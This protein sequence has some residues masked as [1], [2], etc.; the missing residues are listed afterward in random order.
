MI[1]SDVLLRHPAS[2]AELPRDIVVVDW[3]Y[4]PT[5]SF[6]SLQRLQDLGFR[7][8]FVSP[9]LWTWNTFY[10]N[11]AWAFQNISAF[12][13]AGKR[14]G[15]MG[16]VAASWGDNGAENLRENNWPG[17]AYS[18]AAG[19]EV[20]TPSPDPFFRRYVAVQYGVDSPALAEAERLLGWQ[21]FEQ[22][23]WAGRLYHR[24]PLVRSRPIAWTQRMQE[25][26]ADMRRVGSDLTATGPG[27]RFNEDHLAAV[28]HC[29]ARY[30]YIADREL[31]LDSLGRA[32]QRHAFAE[33][34][35]SEQ[36]R[37]NDELSALQSTAGAL[38]RQFGELWLKRNRPEGLAENLARMDRQSTMLGR[39]VRRAREGRLA[40]DSTYSGMQALSGNP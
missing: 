13:A 11:W 31:M 39:L 3:H 32:L 20:G 24:P 1:Y 6:P 26:R 17:Y 12:T 30:G 8:V 15:V 38:R 21:V 18:A 23:G 28:Q 27:V 33:L 9:G 2:A 16:V 40:V 10:P 19:W 29:A 34:P 36:R 35:A 7:D 5:D 22:V 14:A 37:A 4:D 25:L